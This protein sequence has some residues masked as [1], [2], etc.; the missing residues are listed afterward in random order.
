[1]S[2]KTQI[3]NNFSISQSV[4]RCNA[5]QTVAELLKNFQETPHTMKVSAV[6]EKYVNADGLRAVK[7]RFYHLNKAY[8]IPTG[9]FTLEENFID[10][11][12]TG[13]KKAA[14]YN[15][16]ITD[17][18]TTTTTTL[19]LLR[20]QNK[21][22]EF[23]N[24]SAL[25]KFIESGKI[26]DDSEA[27]RQS[28]QH[29]KTYAFG[30]AD[31]QSS[32]EAK[33]RYTQ[34]INKISAFCNSYGSV[35]DLYLPQID[36]A[37]LKD[38]ESYC[39]TTGMTTNGVGVYMRYLRAIYNDAIDRGIIGLDL[40][41]FRRFKI[42]KADTKHRNLDLKDI[43]S[44]IYYN[45]TD[46]PHLQK[47]IDVFLL[48]FYLCGLNVK[49]IL[50]LKKEDIHNQN[51]NILRDKTGVPIRIKIEPEAQTIIDRYQGEKYLLSWLDSYQT[52][53]YRTF[54]RKT[55]KYLKKIFPF[56]S[57][58]WARHTWA[59]MAAE[60]DIPDPIIDIAM[61]HK[62]TGMSAVYIKRNIKKVSAA[63]R[64]VIDLAFKRQTRIVFP[65]KRKKAT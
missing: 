6:L 17:K 64:K 51:I 19:S 58:Y 42:K 8:Y 5:L 41:P 29:F 53:D 14:M 25:K 38:F 9:I 20:K 54:E 22:S 12:I 35:D 59:T 45:C 48:S 61:G 21:L 30:F 33:I 23:K 49:D 36:V 39:L 1:M 40:Y 65:H 50:F 55:N 24:G 26:A 43:R 3:L 52:D 37:W 2:L 60:L 47:Y 15:N 62:L 4:N 27:K 34:A 28:P 56:L 63:N 31:K 44:L 7:V 57:I 46:T 10:G 32:E 13:V 16:I 11:K 18:I